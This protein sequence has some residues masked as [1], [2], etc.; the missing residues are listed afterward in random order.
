M[1]SNAFGSDSPTTAVSPWAA[2]RAAVL[3]H[4]DDERLTGAEALAAHTTG[5]A[6]AARRDGAGVLAVGQPAT[7]AVWET[8][9]GLGSDGLPALAD[10]AP[11]PVCVE[12]VVQ[13]TAIYS[14]ARQ[15]GE[16]RP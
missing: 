12:T 2:V 8:P 4:A 14:Q 10:D 16:E 9:A 11:L 7:Y 3:H 6:Y 15:S 13:G 5:G 1:T